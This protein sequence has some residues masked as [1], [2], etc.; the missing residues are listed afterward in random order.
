MPDTPPRDPYA[1]LRAHAAAQRQATIDRLAAGIA[2]LEAAGRPVTV[3][4]IREVADLDYSAYYRNPEAR[5][6]FRQHS[7]HLRAAREQR[8]TGPRRR[9]RQG[10]QEPPEA[11]PPRDP[12]AAYTK[13]RLMRMISKLR[14]ALAAREA[15]E[16]Q[17]RALLQEHMQCALTI[18]RLQEEASTD[19]AYRELLRSLRAKVEREEQDGMA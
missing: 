10:D 16:Q 9:Q 5:A 8:A 11:R 19:A 17:Y 12:L 4:T 18:A 3:F 13:T 14:Q 6:L 2:A 7:S 1:H 15:L